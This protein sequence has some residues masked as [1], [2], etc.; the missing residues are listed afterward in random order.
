MGIR[1]S[2]DYPVYVLAE[3]ERFILADDIP[4]NGKRGRAVVVYTNLE[5]AQRFIEEEEL[6]AQPFALATACGLRDFLLRRN[7]TV[8]LVAF[9][10]R[11]DASGQP[12]SIWVA[13][14]ERVLRMLPPP[15][16]P[17]DFPLYFVKM[18]KDAAAAVHG[19][20]DQGRQENILAF[21]SDEDLAKRHVAQFAPTGEVRA[22]R[23]P[24]DF[25]QDLRHLDRACFLTFDPPNQTGRIRAVAVTTML[26]MLQGF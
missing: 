5:A 14:V 22:I 20:N 15:G 21:F 18:A 2:W 16:F 25:A 11:Y 12:L 8:T 19:T 4:H 26:E 10:L 3:G 7:D 9:N 23:S 1:I 6:D 17:W 13:P 24:A